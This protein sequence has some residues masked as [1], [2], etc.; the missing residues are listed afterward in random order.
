MLKPGAPRFLW[1]LRAQQ[2]ETLLVSLEE[3]AMPVEDWMS[4]S[5][6]RPGRA[7]G[8]AVPVALEALHVAAEEMRRAAR[9]A[10]GV[11]FADWARL[12]RRMRRGLR[13][14]GF[15]ATDLKSLGAWLEKALVPLGRLT[16][17]SRAPA[18]GPWSSRSVHLALKAHVARREKLLW[19]YQVQLK[20]S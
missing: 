10:G 4:V 9:S 6:W 7:P 2:Q 17:G 12:A 20:G 13:R 15:E 3:F 14:H 5:L 11:A 1:R 18:D 16:V 8:E 19:A